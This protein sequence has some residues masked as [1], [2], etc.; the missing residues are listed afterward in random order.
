MAVKCSWSVDFDVLIQEGRD[1]GAFSRRMAR[2]VC[3]H[4]AAVVSYQRGTNGYCWMPLCDKH[5][6]LPSIPLD[7]WAVKEGERQLSGVDE[8]SY[9]LSFFNIVGG[10]TLKPRA[11]FIETY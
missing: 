4:D 7:E 11:Y 8:H 6:H 10:R 2:T 3:F 5:A 9:L 1:F